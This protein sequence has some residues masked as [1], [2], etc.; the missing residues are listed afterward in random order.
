[1]NVNE[2]TM[3]ASGLRPPLTRG[4]S[5]LLPSISL[6]G[7]YRTRAAI[8]PTSPQQ[9]RSGV[10]L[11]GR[12]YSPVSAA[13][14][15]RETERPE[16][17]TAAEVAGWLR[18]SDDSVYRLVAAGQLRAVK[19]GGLWRFRRADIEELLGGDAT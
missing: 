5:R 19:V 18:I 15:P 4:N 7:E 1:M 11:G 8:P 10:F 13:T 14:A 2:I 17:L 6:T 12:R 3:G 16:L 9:G